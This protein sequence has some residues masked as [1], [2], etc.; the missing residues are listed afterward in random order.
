[1]LRPST[2]AA[3]MAAVPCVALKVV[4]PMPNRMVLGLRTCRL[5]FTLSSCFLRNELLPLQDRKS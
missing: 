1:M 2:S 5:L 3:V 4:M